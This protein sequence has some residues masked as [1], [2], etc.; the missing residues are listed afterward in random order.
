VKASILTGFG[1]PDVLQLR[2]V[3]EPAPDDDDI[4]VR[5]HAASVGFGDT[6]VRNLAAIS[7]RKFHMPLLFWLIAKMVFGVR[8]PRVDILGSEFAGEVEAVGRA[9]TRFA[10]GDSVFG[11][12]GP[13]MGAYAEYL[14]MPEDGVLAAKPANMTYEQAAAIPY[15]AVMALGVLRKARLRP[16]Q[17]VLVVGASGGIGPAILQLAKA[18]FGAEVAGVCG[19]ARLDY[20]RSLGADPAIDYTREDFADRPETYD[21]IIDILGKSSFLRCRKV[22]RPHGRLIFVSFKTAK[23]LQSLWTSVFG[24]RK[25]VCALVTEKQE[26]LVLLKGLIEAGKIGSIVDRSYP[27]AQAAEA[28][29]YAESGAKK[30]YV[31]VSVSPSAD[32]R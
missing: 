23:V 30:G 28:H 29:R 4:L 11:F 24:N 19:T 10:K 2:D 7:P 8:K 15:A 32:T 14:R 12:C 21:L 31:V 13:R 27:L 25:A 5:V 18:H 6:L 3:A 26:D 16:G 9:V 20:I 1:C 22:L 17:R